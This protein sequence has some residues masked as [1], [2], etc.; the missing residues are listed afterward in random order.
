MIGNFSMTILVLNHW[1]EGIMKRFK[2]VSKVFFS[3]ILLSLL[4]GINSLSAETIR[5]G[6]FPI[7][8]MIENEQQGRFID[9]TK[10]IAGRAGLTITIRV[11]PPKRT[12]QEF[13]DQEVDV[14]FPAVDEKFAAG[15]LPLRSTVPIFFRKN[16]IFTLKDAPL[17]T[18]IAQLQGKVVGITLGYAYPKALMEN[19]AVTVKTAPGDVNNAKKMEAGRIDAFIVEEQSG[20]RAFELV[21]MRE[22][23]QYDPAS[24]ISTQEVY[25]AFQRTQQGQKLSELI[26]KVLA[27]M[28]A[29]GTFDRILNPKQ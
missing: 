29:D 14:L 15:A 4:F 27:E 18:S 3:I 11:K 1:E 20:L 8:G 12:F 13:A 5:F 6:T 17:F 23:I 28:K 22:R 16:Y 10:E 7:P 24:P 25:Y 19:E 26:S 21:G 2:I 9:L